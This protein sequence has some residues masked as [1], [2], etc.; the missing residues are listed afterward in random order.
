MIR[1]QGINF[2]HSR[3]QQL[4]AGYIQMLFYTVRLLQ[5]YYSKAAG[6]LLLTHYQRDDRQANIT[7]LWSFLILSIEHVLLLGK[8]KNPLCNTLHDEISS[9]PICMCTHHSFQLTRKT[10]KCIHLIVYHTGSQHIIHLLCISY[11]RNLSIHKLI[12]Q[13][14]PRLKAIRCYAF[15][16]CDQPSIQ[17]YIPEC[18]SQSINYIAS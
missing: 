5:W 1:F 10:P 15:F 11:Q 3:Q 18:L 6:T 7:K 8:F 12:P 9:G 4:S 14:M 2:L 17:R 13:S 16:I